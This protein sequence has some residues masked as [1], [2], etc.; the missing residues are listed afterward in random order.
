[1]SSTP[2]G[3]QISVAIDGQAIL[4]KGEFTY[5][6]GTPKREMIVGVSGVH[7]FKEMPTVPYIEGTATDFQG[8]DV[9]ALFNTIDATVTIALRNGKTVVLRD[10][11]YSGDPQVGTEEGEIAIKFEGRTASEF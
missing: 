9:R 7:G 6:L 10:A 5:S 4:A 2:I 1:M 11:V 8:L 3:G